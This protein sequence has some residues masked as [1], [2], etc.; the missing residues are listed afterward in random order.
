[1][2]GGEM[3]IKD[4]GFGSAAGTVGIEFKGPIGNHGNSIVAISGSQ[5]GG[6]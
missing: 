6:P 5:D 4:F 2:F 1:M 3:E